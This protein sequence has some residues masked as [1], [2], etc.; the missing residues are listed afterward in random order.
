M[1]GA[2]SNA[3]YFACWH[4]KDSNK[5]YHYNTIKF[6]R[7]AHP[8]LGDDPAADMPQLKRVFLWLTARSAALFS[9]NTSVKFINAINNNFTLMSYISKYQVGNLDFTRQKH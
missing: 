7:W 2:Y 3:N 4:N 9:G 6:K 8:R 5:E 1:K